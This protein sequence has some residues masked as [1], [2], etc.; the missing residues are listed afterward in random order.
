MYTTAPN[1]IDSWV[2]VAYNV[3]VFLRTE[4]RQALKSTV[5][6]G[7]GSIQADG[8]DYRPGGR[9]VM[10]FEGWVCMQRVFNFRMRFS[11]TDIENKEGETTRG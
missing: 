4:Q 6:W 3:T 10:S 5:M 1:I 8:L 9:V 11:S 7:A 2:Q